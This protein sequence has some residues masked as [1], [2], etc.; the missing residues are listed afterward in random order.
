MRIELTQQTRNRALVERLLGSDRLGGVLLENGVCA[1][2]GL[3]LGIE[4]IVAS[5]QRGG[6]NQQSCGEAQHQSS[7][8]SAMLIWTDGK[9]FGL[10]RPSSK[11]PEL[12]S[13][14]SWRRRTCT[15]P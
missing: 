7:Q 3:H 2:D 13:L 14:P 5:P 11:I 12:R 9:C 4:R 10:R 1:N 6:A 15:V 8:I